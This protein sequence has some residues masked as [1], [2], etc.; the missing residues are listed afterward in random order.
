[1]ANLAR[2]TNNEWTRM[3]SV[4]CLH[5]LA[6]DYCSSSTGG[7]PW[8]QVHFV[9]T[10][11]TLLTVP[12]QVVTKI[13]VLDGQVSFAAR[14]LEPDRRGQSDHNPR[15]T[16]DS[17]SVRLAMHSQVRP[18]HEIS[19]SVRYTSTMCALFAGTRATGCIVGRQRSDQK[20]SGSPYSGEKFRHCTNY[21]GLP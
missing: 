20:L 7:C 11:S 19:F 21:I 12:A 6:E 17:S 10:S 15:V 3:W 9:S 4:A 13:N 2:N 8:V 14:G 1:M 5:H 18:R 16:V